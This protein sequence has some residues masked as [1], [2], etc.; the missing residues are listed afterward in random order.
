MS[1]LPLMRYREL[2]D[3]EDWNALIE[4][5]KDS[6][7]ALRGRVVWNI[8]S[9]ALGGGV[10][11]MLHSLLPYIRGAG[12]DARWMVITAKPPFFE[13]T[14]RLYNMVQG[15]AGDKGQLGEQERAIYD[16]TISLN[17]EQLL[18]A[19]Q[20]QDI[21]I[22]HD[23]PTAGLVK[24]IKEK[25]AGVV[26]RCHVGTDTP[27]EFSR[28]GWSFLLP[29]VDAADAYIFSCRSF[30]PD[31]I[32]RSRVE[33]IPPSIEAFSPKN[34]DMDP[35]VVRGILHHAGLVRGEVPKGG[36][37][38]FTRQ[39]G[40]P[41]RVDHKAEVIRAGPPPDFETPLIVQVSRWDRLKD[42]KGVL[43]GF[44]EHAASLCDAHLV[45][46]GPAV[47]S[48]SDD[49]EGAQALSETLMIWRSLPQA[50][51]KRCHLASLPM[52]DVEENAAMVNALQR[53]GTVLVQKSLQEGFGLT[54]TE[55]MWKAR[56]VVASAV[57]GVREQIEDGVSGLLLPDAADLLHFGETVLRPLKD[58]DLAKRL[59]D[60]ARQR[61]RKTFLNNRHLV[62]YVGLLKKLC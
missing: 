57:G 27:N 24:P 13:V 11:E 35:A 34:Q 40:S 21:V 14:K 1:P 19:I 43:V 51:Q 4:A 26:W 22:L 38:I 28:A 23:P 50:I 7:K 54:V 39:D 31:G 30:I 5:W 44:T 20:S 55:A 8:N 53:H 59:G 56:P 32:D 29:Y 6:G 25:G 61:V 36:F 60:G 47:H 17:A 37:P 2:L 15:D 62:Q 48:V 49:P 18:S 10:A 3:E 9:T 52:Q 45:L 58:A 12:V 42:P 16:K 41:A 46:A 33:V